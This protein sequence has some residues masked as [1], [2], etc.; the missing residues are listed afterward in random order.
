[1]T[2]LFALF[3]AIGITAATPTLPQATGG[4]GGPVCTAPDDSI[5]AW[6]R[7]SDAEPVLGGITG[8]RGS[9]VMSIWRLPGG[10][11]VLAMDETGG[12]MKC[13]IMTGTDLTDLRVAPGL[14]G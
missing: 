1:M 5:N 10:R 4:R 6:M 12:G 7:R 14:P 13:V 9:M 11:W 2:R 3:A 8:P